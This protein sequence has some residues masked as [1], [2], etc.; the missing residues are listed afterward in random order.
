MGV[1]LLGL[2]VIIGFS[3]FVRKK[4][5]WSVNVTRKLVHITAGVLIALT[6][7]LLENSNPLFVIAGFFIVL[8]FF[9][10]K[11]GWMP[12]MHAT[13]RVSYGTVFYPL[14][15]LILVL[16]LWDDYKSILVIA[17]LIM[18][19]ADAVA[20]IV[21]EN[22][23]NPLTFQYSGEKKSL[24]GSL[25][26][27]LAAFIIALFGLKFISPIDN[28]SI[29]W[30]NIFWYSSIVALIAAASEAVSFKGLDNI[31]VPLASAFILHYYVAHSPEQNASLTF[32]VLLALAIAVVSFHLRFLSV[33]GALATFLLGSVVFG[34]GKW[35]FS[36][37]LLLFFVL[38]S[39][40]SKVGKK[41]KKQF[42]DTFQKGGQ[43]DLGQVF[44]NGGIAGIFVLFW[45]FFPQQ[46]FYMAFVGSIAAVTADT[47]GTEIGVFSKIKPRNIIN[48][49]KVPPGTSG[50]VTAVGFLGGLLG[51]LIIVLLSKQVTNYYDGLL[52]GL[53]ALIIIAGLFGSVIDSIVGATIQAQFKCPNCGKITEKKLHCENHQTNIDSGFKMI[54]NDVVNAICALSGA[55][56]AALAYLVVI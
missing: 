11:K 34:I 2:M 55:V 28:I 54:D 51:S 27:L 6:P 35:E 32:G 19:V 40:L 49:K 21:G 33:T 5:K 52:L 41:K 46:I 13:D 42:A 38:S 16:L 43:R 1:L 3:E 47:W 56:F 20:A 8:N 25:V 23:K 53:P 9:A 39:L 45:N 22:L 31:S 44:A 30:L 12:G 29:S 17:M 7:F 26:M 36:L 10:I 37:P 4:S 50:G 14:S 15:F 18:A 48:F 24:Q